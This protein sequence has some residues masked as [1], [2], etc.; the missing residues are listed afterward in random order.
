MNT[1]YALI[2][3]L[4]GTL[5]DS[6]E[7]V[8][9][10]WREVALRRYGESDIDLQKV[11]S[12]MGLPMNELALA[13]AP[14]NLPEK[15]KFAFAEEAFF[16]ENQYLQ[17]HPGI[18]FEGVAKTLTLLKESG[19]RLF[20]VSNCQKGYIE[21]FLPTIPKGLIEGF[22][23]YGD[24][25]GQKSETIIALKEKYSLDRCVYIGDTEGDEI[26]AKLAGCLFC[27]AGYGFGKSQAPDFVINSFEE[28][29][30]LFR[31]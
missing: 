16:Y 14:E 25:L 20:I 4:D 6:R 21:T 28:L 30:E 2:F 23:C 17:I 15:E 5:W 26:Q 3:D 18:P 10:A 22:L 29:L 12:V 24:T 11:Q 8:A 31:N 7:Q 13:I 19:V 27:F 1:D 9:S